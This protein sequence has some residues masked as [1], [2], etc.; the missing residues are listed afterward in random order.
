MHKKSVEA[1]ITLESEEVRSGAEQNSDSIVA[2]RARAKEHNA[3]LL[4]AMSND[5]LIPSGDTKHRVDNFSF[6]DL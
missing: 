6:K 3:K 2:I 4:T 5:E 1:A